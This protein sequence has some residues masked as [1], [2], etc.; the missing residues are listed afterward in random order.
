MFKGREAK[1][2]EIVFFYDISQ[3]L[4]K[5]REE[6]ENKHIKVLRRMAVLEIGALQS[7]RHFTKTVRSQGSAGHGFIRI[8]FIIL[9]IP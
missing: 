7:D 2:L 5:I 3:R 4:W 6:M 9:P 1:G 8:K